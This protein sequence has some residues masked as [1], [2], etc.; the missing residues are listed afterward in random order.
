MTKKLEDML[1]NGLLKEE[2]DFWESDIWLKLCCMYEMNWTSTMIVSGCCHKRD[3]NNENWYWYKNVVCVSRDVSID[4]FCCSFLFCLFL[5]KARQ[6]QYVC[7]IFTFWS[8]SHC[9]FILRNINL[10]LNKPY[11][12]SGFSRS[13][14]MLTSNPVCSWC[15][16]VSWLSVVKKMTVCLVSR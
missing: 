3:C 14:K 11:S 13:N 5:F 4:S 12:D 2:E 15:C 1:L 8:S 16:I 7:F 9:F 10:P 6:C